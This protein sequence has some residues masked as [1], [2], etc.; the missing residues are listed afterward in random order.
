MEYWQRLEY[1]L[2]V[3]YMIGGVKGIHGPLDAYESNQMHT[4]LVLLSS[5][6][7]DNLK[8]DVIQL[9]HSVDKVYSVADAV[10]VMLSSNIN[11]EF[12]WCKIV[13][14]PKVPSKV[15]I[16][17]W[18]VIQGGV[19]VKEFLSYKHCL[20]DGSDDK[21]GWCLEHAESI[22]HLLLHCSWTFKLWEALFNWW[23]ISWVMP[24]S[25]VKFALDWHYGMGVKA[26]KFWS[27]IGPASLWTIWIA[28]NEVVFNGRYSCWAS[29]V[30]RIKI[31][32]FQWLEASKVF[33]SHQF[34]IRSTRSTQPWLLI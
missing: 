33:S 2:L 11:S 1:F 3:R 22:D 12:D 30:N 32:V 28:R 34:Y 26:S 18:L 24:S 14:N 6:A 9:V 15:A 16:F 31:K 21:C 4:L 29:V 20:R 27:L 17:L 7:L 13:W 8:D 10:R 25:M 5:V 19:P 23:N